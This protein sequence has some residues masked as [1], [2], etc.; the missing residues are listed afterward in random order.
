MVSDTTTHNLYQVLA[1]ALRIADDRDRRRRVIVSE[2]DNF[3][4]DLYVAAG[5]DRLPRPGL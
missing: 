5:P 4:T 3:P 1:A 2:R